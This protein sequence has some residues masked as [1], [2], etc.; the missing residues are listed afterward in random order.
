MLGERLRSILNTKGITVSEFANM[1]D[2]PVETVKNVYYGKTTDP[3]ISTVMQMANA[4]GMSVNCLMG[5]C[6]HTKEERAL[7]QHYR[8]CGNHGQSLIRLTA[9]Y[10]ALTA[11]AERD[12]IGRHKIP[13]LIPHGDIHGG[14]VYDAC[15]VVEVETNVAE[16][17]VSIRMPNNDL[18]PIYCKNDVILLANY[19]PANNQ[20]AVFYKNGKA[21]I[22]K[23]ME[24]D[25]QY[26][27]KCLHNMGEDMI[28]RR[29]DQI[30]YI[31]TCCGVIRV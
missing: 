9:K 13:C 16:A 26:R 29:M 3:K 14:I 7:L 2:L 15:E 12:A 22:R 5:Q 30:D 11:K 1:C 17:Y 19:F 18:A 23:Y 25:G 6:S 27:L 20:Y 24:E 28:F 31:G 8:A 21:Y 10:E 4:L